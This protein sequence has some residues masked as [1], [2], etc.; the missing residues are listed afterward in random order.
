M[1]YFLFHQH[2]IKNFGLVDILVIGVKN[3]TIKHDSEQKLPGDTFNRH[4]YYYYRRKNR[5]RK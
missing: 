1:V 3:D 2:K 5:H 4:G